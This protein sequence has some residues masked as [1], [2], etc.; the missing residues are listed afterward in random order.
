MVKLETQDHQQLVI[1]LQDTQPMQTEAARRQMLAFAGLAPILPL[2]DISGPAFVAVNTIIGFL[3]NYG[4]LTY[5]NEALGQF[6][7]AVKQVVGVEQQDEIDTLLLKYEMMEPVAP[8]ELLD[9]WK[10][11]DDPATVQ[12]KIIGIDTLR[13]IA[14][15][16][17]GLEVSRS[18]AFISVHGLG[19]RWSGTGFL[20]AP[21]LMMTNHHMV[22]ESSLLPGVL[23]RF[24]YQENFVGEAQLTKEYR[25]I[26]DGLFHANE[27]LDYAIFQVENRPGDEWGWLPLA[28]RDIRKDE[29]INIIQHPNGLPKQVSL[30]NNLVQY[31]GGNVVQYV[32]STNPGSSGSP[33][34][35]DA[36]EVV[37]LH[38]AGGVLP[39]PSTGR[40][41]LRNQ[42]ILLSRILNDLPIELKQMVQAGAAL[43]PES[44]SLKD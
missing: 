20:V 32:T 44:P 41:H 12:E 28:Q 31:V 39:E 33:V 26:A 35:N 42:G 14:F 16:E 10:G 19:K 38:H 13:P 29:R 43:P 3:A 4:R 21:D 8:G 27:T 17:R 37:A 18:V 24:N 15:L 11:T 25:A 5:D 9:D 36:W 40:R 6:L 30:Q 23:L 1:L 22:W 7:N 2:I 34:L